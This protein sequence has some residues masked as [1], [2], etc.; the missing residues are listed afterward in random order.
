MKISILVTLTT[1]LLGS[2][3]I[4]YCIKD[5]LL[6]V[7]AINYFSSNYEEAR[8]KFLNASRAAGAHIESFE[9]HLTEPEGASLF[10]DVAL[11]G[12]KDADTILVLGSGTHGVEG[13]TGS[14]IQT[15]L[16]REGIASDLKPG[17]S[18]ALIHAINPYGFAHLRRFNENNI[19]LNRNFLD[20]SKPYPVNPG[21]EELADVVSPK[22]ISFWSNLLAIFKLFKYRLIN[23][24]AELRK[25]ITG[26]QYTDPQGIFYGGQNE[27][28]SNM[29][30]RVIAKRYLSKA[31]RVVVIDF[32]TGLGPYGNA[33]VIL[34]EEKY[35]PAYKRA[36]EWWGDKAKTTASGE[37]VSVH[38]DT[39][40]KRAFSQM[41]PKT[42][43]T[44]VTMEFGTYSDLK[45]L[46]ALRA[47]NWLHNYGAK[48]YP[49][50]SR[51][52]TNLLRMFYPDDDTWKLKVWKQGQKFVKQ[53][54][55]H[56]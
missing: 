45:V 47:E 21:Y 8:R 32:H 28:W 12:S 39:T 43:V 37:S 24:R 19:D 18:I 5:N 1:V 16:L 53:V 25:A 40:L 26:G 33:E 41:L 36:V 6:D 44:A 15:G 31:K 49:E 9:N 7:E 3:G 27:T 20:H 51:I 50:S 2:V 46:W 10:T 29:T 22:S 48:E 30:I 38:L 52:K 55:A 11:I 4:G 54:L 35:S 23:S 42:E 34:N 13:F 17:M 56:F 14:A